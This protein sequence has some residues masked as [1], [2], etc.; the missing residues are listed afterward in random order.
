[1]SQQQRRE[2][3][4]QLI[5]CV[6]ERMDSALAYNT[7]VGCRR[8]HSKRDIAIALGKAPGAGKAEVTSARRRLLAHVHE[9]KRV[10]AGLTFYEVWQA[11]L[12]ARALVEMG[13][14]IAA[15]DDP[16]GVP[17]VTV[18]DWPCPDMAGRPSSSNQPPPQGA[19]DL[20]RHAAHLAWAREQL[21]TREGRRGTTHGTGAR[22]RLDEEIHS[23]REYIN[24][25]E[26]AYARAHTSENARGRHPRGAASAGGAAAAADAAARA[27]QRQ[28]R[29]QQNA[30]R[31]EQTRAVISSK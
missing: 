18:P 17:P 20:E 31:R 26:A 25:E 28:H 15:W 16:A 30:Q 11:E 13:P 12:V 1:M 2:A 8:F 22:D 27:A 21:R 4:A 5:A 6:F 19:T 9:D 29:Q 23:W 24:E 3:L 7:A 10:G 14:A